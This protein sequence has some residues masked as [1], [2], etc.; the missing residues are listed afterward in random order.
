MTTTQT[1]KICHRRILQNGRA[2]TV[3]QWIR[4]FVLKYNRPEGWT[5]NEIAEELDLRLATVTGQVNLL[6]DDEILRRGDKR[7]DVHT[8]YTAAPL[9]PQPLVQGQLV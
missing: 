5:A 2:E 9:Y 3:R 7:R 6:V 8:T 1:S 4:R